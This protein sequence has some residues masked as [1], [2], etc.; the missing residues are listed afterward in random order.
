MLVLIMGCVGLGLNVLV[1]S[2]LHGTYCITSP[3]APP[4]TESEHSH[5][6]GHGHGRGHSP[7]HEQ[8]HHRGDTPIAGTHNDTSSS[9]AIADERGIELHHGSN[10]VSAPM[11]R[12]RV[13]LT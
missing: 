2:F 8:S 12:L 5:D 6:H 3:D 9:P 4:K 13:T 10:A 11:I 7:T 1:M